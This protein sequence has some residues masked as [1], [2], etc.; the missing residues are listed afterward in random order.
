MPM[1]LL[2]TGAGGMLGSALTRELLAQGH[3]VS[4]LVRP[5]S[6]LHRIHD[7]LPRLRRL[8]DDGRDDA[9]RGFLLER[10]PEVV[11]HTACAYGRRGESLTALL[12][13]NLR[14]GVRLLDAL[15]SLPGAACLLHA[16]TALPPQTSDYALSKHQFAA[17]AARRALASGARLQSVELRLQHF[18]GPGDGADKF[19]TLVLRRCRA[20]G[21][22]ALTACEQRRDLVH[23]DDAV[24][25][26]LAVLAHRGELAQADAV[27]IGSGQAWPLRRYVET[28]HRL[29]GSHT[30]LD[31]GALPM[32][33]GEPACCQADVSRL[34]GWGWA[35]RYTLEAGIRDLIERDPST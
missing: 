33:P 31:F 29:T 26:V 16:G 28:V 32:R 23:I 5:G 12:D 15:A 24:R 6:D 21:E 9:L 2:V 22:L 19:T 7:L 30:R 34:A 3:A 13:A 8:E 27:D 11:L 25:A 10:P 18:Y 4:V 1:E 35:P 14:L 17:W 20:G